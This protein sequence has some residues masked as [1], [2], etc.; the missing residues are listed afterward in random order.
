MPS[1]VWCRLPERSSLGRA[2]R[3]DPV[4]CAFF[5]SPPPHL[6]GCGQ[7]APITAML[8]DGLSSPPLGH[9][10]SLRDRPPSA[11][12]KNFVQ[13]FPRLSGGLSGF[14][15]R[16]LDLGSRRADNGPPP[17]R[18]S[19]AAARNTP[20]TCGLAVKI[21]WSACELGGALQVVG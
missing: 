8:V 11:W 12:I 10:R 15:K 20:L 4:C 21:L 7:M 17:T 5:W 2:E 13:W 14:E 3:T 1:R 16:G 9:A 6:V 18:G 19:G